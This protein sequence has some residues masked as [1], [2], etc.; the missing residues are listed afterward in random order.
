[1]AVLRFIAV[2]LG[3]TQIRTARYT[4]DGVQEARVA[5]STGSEDGMDFVLRRVRSAIRQVWPL[6]GPV[7]AIGIGVPGP[8][9]YKHGIL[10]FA[11][12]LPESQNIPFRNLLVNTFGVPVFVGNDAD[13]AALAEHRFGAGQGVSDMIYMTI[14]TGIGGGMIFNNRLFTGGNGLG[15]E[16]GH[17]TL[18]IHGLKCGCGNYG[19]LET[20]SSGTAIARQMQ[21]R[22]AAG[23][24]SVLTER[25]GGDISKITAKEVSMAA[26]EGDEL[27]KSV[28]EQ[29]GIYL[30]TAIVSLMYMLNP[31]LFVLGGSVTKAGDLL[32]GPVQS[33]IT[34]RAPAIYQAQTRVVPAQLGADV[35]LWGALALCLMELEL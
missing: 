29:A 23:E 12:N 31:S 11:P 2:D 22:I 27:A 28:F 30:G 4:A 1:M 14:S 17:I 15:G 13:V 6:E 25:V 24:F 35:G 7:A 34:E 32:F 10:R 16:I 26:Q 21:E 3:G 20:L 9:D 18:D 5:M 8:V 33:V 19:C